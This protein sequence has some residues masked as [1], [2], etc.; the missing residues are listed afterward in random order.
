M[1]AVAAAVAATAPAA[2]VDPSD[3]GHYHPSGA[4]SSTSGGAGGKGGA[5]G[6]GCGDGTQKSG[7]LCFA[8]AQTVATQVG[9]L[10]DVTALHCGTTASV[11]VLGKTPMNYA[12]E[13]LRGD[14]K[15]GLV[16]AATTAITPVTVA[17]AALAAGPL[18][19]VGQDAVFIVPGGAPWGMVL[20]DGDMCK[21]PAIHVPAVDAAPTQPARGAAHFLL[22]GGQG[23]FA[24]GWGDAIATLTNYN[25]SSHSAVSQTVDVL[26]AGDFDGNGEDEFAYANTL[27]TMHLGNF[28]TMVSAKPIGL[29][30]GDFDGDKDVDV[31]MCT[32]AGEVTLYVND[33]KASFAPA[34]TVHAMSLSAV[35][36]IAAGDVDGDD[37]L[38]VVLLGTGA[39]GAA[40]EILIGA[41]QLTFARSLDL[42]NA[43]PV[44]VALGDFNG[45]HALDIVTSHAGASGALSLV[46]SQP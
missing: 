9:E 4:A 26:A 19:S 13:V 21:A 33:G 27:G 40:V 37:H 39:K 17:P 14:A 32:S 1:M 7:E 22:K 34:P 12:L 38:D 43:S 35:V 11:A 25:A 30:T 10:G 20:F 2:C 18:G 16:H 36:D 8:P 31:V 23:A 3:G 29:V 15:A 45:D 46:Q 44:A 41:K 24:S 42:P 6:A 28:A 5:G